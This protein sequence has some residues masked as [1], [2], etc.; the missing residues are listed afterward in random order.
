M[1]TLEDLWAV[2]WPPAP[3]ET[4]FCVFLQLTGSVL[5]FSR[6]TNVTFTET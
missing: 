4:Q 3:T 1:V 5:V 6:G 2:A